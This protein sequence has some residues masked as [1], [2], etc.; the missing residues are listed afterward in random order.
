MSGRTNSLSRS[1]VTEPSAELH[2]FREL[3]RSDNRRGL[4]LA[5]GTGF[6][7]SRDALARGLLAIGATPNMLTVAGFA[8][9]CAGG[10]CFLFGAGHVLPGRAGATLAPGSWWPLAG[11]CCLILAG[12]M[13]M[14]DGALARLGSLQSRFGAVL[15]S[16][17]DRCSDL[18]VF[19][20]CALHFAAVGN[21]TYVGLSLL[22]LAAAQLT[23]YIK[24]RAE[25][26]VPNFGAGYWQRGERVAALVIAG[27]AGHIPAALWLTGVMPLFTVLRRLRYVRSLLSESGPP[28]ALTGLKWA[29]TPWR[30]PRG[31]LGYDLV[32][33]TNIAFLI[34]GPWI[35][36]FFYASSDPLGDLVRHLGL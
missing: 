32:T 3:H 4:S 12:A 2:D 31:S 28:P 8:A 30:H 20:G 1:N 21:V 33:G 26:L 19:G 16:F 17:L 27:L 7:R 14:L 11:A 9:T 22:A 10:V 36:A 18:V 34:V 13:D 6:V 23:S 29:L 24:A 35:W 25:S 5:I 15:D